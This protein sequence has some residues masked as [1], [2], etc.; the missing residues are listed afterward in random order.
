MTT[1]NSRLSLIIEARNRAS[2]ALR[3]VT[4]DMGQMTGAGR[5]LQGT[6]Q[7]IQSSIVGLTLLAP[8]LATSLAG[9]AINENM[10]QIIEYERGLRRARVQ[11][12]LMGFTVTEAGD[13]IERLNK[14]MGTQS[15][16]ALVA[17]AEALRSVALAGDNLIEQVHPLALGF[18]ELLDLDIAETMDAI[19]T[20]ITQLDPSKFIQL[21]GAVEGLDLDRDSGVLKALEVGDV[22]PFMRMLT[23]F[24]RDEQLSARELLMKNARDL[25]EL[26]IPAQ[27]AISEAA[28][29]FANVLVLSIIKAIENSRA[30]YELAIGAA[31]ASIQWQRIPIDTEPIAAHTN[32]MSIA[33]WDKF[34]GSMTDPRSRITASTIGRNASNIFGSAFDKSLTGV[35]ATS[36]LNTTTSRWW[37][38]FRLAMT[39]TNSATVATTIGRG[40]SNLFTTAFDKSLTGATSVSNLNATSSRWW[41]NLRL[42]MLKDSGLRTT[43]GSLAAGLRDSFRNRL[44]GLNMDPKPGTF[45]RINWGS[46]ARAMSNSLA[47][48]MVGF[49]LPT[50]M[51]N[52]PEVLSNVELLGVSVIAASALGNKLGFNL[53]TTITATALIVFGPGLVDLFERLEIDDKV[54]LAVAGLGFVIA[55]RL[56][57]G[58]FNSL[59]IGTIIIQSIRDIRN[60]DEAKLAMGILGGII[61]F[62]V[63]GRFG[64]VFSAILGAELG[65]GAREQFRGKGSEEVFK[66]VD[67]FMLKLGNE[68]SAVAW[69]ILDSINYLILGTLLTISGYI[70]AIITDLAS[71]VIGVFANIGRLISDI[72]SLILNDPMKAAGS[73]IQDLV[74][75]FMKDT[76]DWNK[77]SDFSPVDD[78]FKMNALKALQMQESGTITQQ[79]FA[80]SYLRLNPSTHG[81]ERPSEQQQSSDNMLSGMLASLYKEL[82]DLKAARDQDT[83]DLYGQYGGTDGGG[84]V[85][86]DDV[87]GPARP[88]GEGGSP[89]ERG[90]EDWD[91]TYRRFEPLVVELKLDRKVIERIAVEGVYRVAKDK[92]GLF[93][94][95]ME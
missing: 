47:L 46:T 10:R 13:R 81:P 8:I 43:G 80:S 64:R 28:A 53:A 84:F 59:A 18:A 60:D 68:L 21:V 77:T 11:L 49:L 85:L 39:G 35:T 94:G 89:L 86:P 58:L 45:S 73:G 90:M 27:D 67:A 61:G 70:E 31:L 74:S 82:D 72:V 63:G 36:N 3:S 48:G 95:S 51:T 5:N 79:L 55:R 19:V 7:L 6:L 75:Q 66:E 91:E 26:V 56:G 1:S 65:R 44:S 16:R 2:S 34:K 88:S 25:L 38:N 23:D 41:T 17:N 93:K 57:Q 29:T 30:G 37:T 20:A 71:N 42:A 33:W 14:I 50:L 52:I 15:H 92:G 40:T 69:F 24:V 54:M 9:I 22:E 78:V 32:R 4:K 62:T 83:S 76:M 87:Y 12:Q